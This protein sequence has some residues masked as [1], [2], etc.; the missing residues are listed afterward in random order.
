MKNG[1][2]ASDSFSLKNMQQKC[3]L[4]YKF[5]LHFG[6]N[7][8]VQRNVEICIQLCRQKISQKL[9]RFVKSQ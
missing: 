1:V 6:F 4:Q 5:N 3:R 2:Y 8:L 9:I 7:F